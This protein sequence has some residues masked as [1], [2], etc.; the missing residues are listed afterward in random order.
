MYPL[1]R[2]KTIEDVIKEVDAMCQCYKNSFNGVYWTDENGI[3]N[4]LT[5]EQ[6]N[7]LKQ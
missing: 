3:R 6:I 7:Q 4:E 1:I 5:W 2:A